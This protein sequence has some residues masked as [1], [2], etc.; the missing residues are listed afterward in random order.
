MC[1]REQYLQNPRNPT[2][3]L[4]IPEQFSGGGNTSTSRRRMVTIAKPTGA[5]TPQSSAR[6][7]GSHPSVGKGDRRHTLKKR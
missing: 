5:V 1:T 4:P 3:G 2:Y 7:H 6:R